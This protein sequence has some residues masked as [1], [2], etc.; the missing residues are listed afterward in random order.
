[1]ET[2]MGSTTTT[3]TTTTPIRTNEAYPEQT[4]E[5]IAQLF[6]RLATRHID[7]VRSN[8]WTHPDW[9]AVV[10]EDFRTFVPSAW[11]YPA[12]DGRAEYIESSRVFKAANPAYDLVPT[13]MDAVVDPSQ[14][15]GRVWVTLHVYGHPP[16]LVRE[17]VC[18]MHF[19]LTRRG[20]RLVRQ[21]ALRGPQ[22]M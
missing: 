11:P 7:L 16:P 17:S 3:T 10:A 14:T 12:A 15:E 2:D 13:R 8:N 5:D 4:E 18:I 22:E 20:W 21:E 19:Q 6:K 9:T 1:M